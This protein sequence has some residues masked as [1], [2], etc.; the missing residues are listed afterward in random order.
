MTL[1]HDITCTRLYINFKYLNSFN[2]LL[3]FIPENKFLNSK[4]RFLYILF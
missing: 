4:R 3:H 1:L 2:I